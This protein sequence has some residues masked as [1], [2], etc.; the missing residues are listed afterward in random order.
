[1]PNGAVRR[2]RTVVVLALVIG[3]ALAACRSGDRRPG[4]STASAPP[5]GAGPLWL[6]AQAPSGDAVHATDSE[7]TLVRRY[8]AVNVKRDSLPGA[9]G[10]SIWGTVLFPGDSLRTLYVYWDDSLPFRRP[11][12]VRTGPG[13]TAWTVWP[14]VSVGSSL[15]DVE[16]LN[17]RPFRL[18]GF[19]FDYGGI[20]IAWDGGRLDAL[21]HPKDATAG[22]VGVDFAPTRDVAAV[23]GEGEHSS[24]LPAMRSAEPRVGTLTVTVR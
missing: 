8:G 22:W 14:G 13:A 10:E 18:N 21:W 3:S 24:A 15:A 20:V 4:D 17:G 12:D 23:E 2:P 7:S 9:E 5:A 11:A 1:M 16:R 6:F 19:G